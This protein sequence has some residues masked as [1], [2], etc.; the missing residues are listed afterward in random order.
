MTR[1]VCGILTV[2]AFYLAWIDE[3][4]GIDHVIATTDASWKFI[5]FLL[6]FFIFEELALLYFDLK[7]RS[8]SKALH[9]HHFFAFNGFFLAEYYNCG[10]YYA[11]KP[12]M[13]KA[14]TPFSCVCWC[15]LKLELE[16]TKAWKIDQWILI[17]I[18]HIRSFLEFLWW[19]DI[20]RDWDNIKQNLPLPYLINMLVGLTLLSL[21]LTPYWT[22]KKT[23]QYFHPTDWNIENTNK[24]S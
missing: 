15:L 4:L 5:S 14:G 12:F 19:C 11:A 3:R 13:L 17:N 23:V 18:F 24:R 8:F 22:Y 9:L 21:W 1:A 20:Y 7:Y 2:W 10:H 6:V 16:K